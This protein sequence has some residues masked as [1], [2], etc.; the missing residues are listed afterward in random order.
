MLGRT[1]AGAARSGA[2]F[3]NT[4][5]IAIA[6]NTSVVMASPRSAR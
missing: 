6:A 2:V 5:A 3:A 4:I 1:I